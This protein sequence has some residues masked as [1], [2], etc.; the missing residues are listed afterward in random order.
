MSASS[1]IQRVAGLVLLNLEAQES[2]DGFNGFFVRRGNNNA[3]P[4]RSFLERILNIFPQP[5]HFRYSGRNGIVNKHRNVEIAAL[6]CFCDV[7]QVHPDFVSIGSIGGVFSLDL[8][9]STLRVQ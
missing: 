5:F 1:D 2:M 4:I 9:H 3:S 6:K 8:N 7:S